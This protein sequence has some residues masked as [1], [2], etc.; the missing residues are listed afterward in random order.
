MTWFKVDDGLWGHPKWLATPPGARALWVTAGSW[1]SANLTDGQIPRHVLPTLGGKTK[2]AATLVDVGLW[3]ATSGGWAFHEWNQPGR[4]PTK[5]AV[6]AE[7]EAAAER[8]RRAREKAAQ[9]KSRSE[10]RRDMSVSHGP[11]VPSR[12]VPKTNPPLLTQVCRRLFGDATKPTDDERADLWSLWAE[13]AGQG[14]DLEAELKSWLIF[15][16]VTDLRHPG[17]ALLGWLRT[18]AK[19]ASIPT[20]PGCDR[21]VRGWLPDEFGQPSANRC[22]ACRSHLQAVGAS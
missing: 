21:C 2:D 4:Q 16:G 10:S 5:E 11:P 13:T 20:L 12:P 7:R 22:V 15:N 17:A 19:R 6:M 8:Q 3:L 9:K 14:V 18:A 1:S